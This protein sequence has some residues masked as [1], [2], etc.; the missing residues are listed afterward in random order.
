VPKDLDAQ[1]FDKFIAAGFFKGLSAESKAKWRKMAAE[2]EGQVTGIQMSLGAVTGGEGQIGLVYVI[3]CK[4]ADKLMG[5][6]PDYVGVMSEIYKA[7]EGEIVSKLELKYHKGLEGV[8]DTKL[9]AISI[10]HPVLTALPEGDR[11]KLKAVLGDDKIRFLVGK[12]D[13]KTVVM[14]LGGGKKF[15]ATAMATAKARSGKIPADPGAAKALAM[16]PKK[17]VGVGLLNLGNI[18]PVVKKVAAALGETPP[19]INLIAPTPLAGSIS[20]EKS[21]VLVVGYIPTDAIQGIVGAVMGAIMGGMM[22]GGGGPGAG[23]P[24]GF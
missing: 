19:P 18:M 3:E 20:I 13:A 17:R 16:L 10:E 5:M 23:G 8:G 11:A 15:V 14:T 7:T 22:G 24:G 6:L 12:A 21:D 1:M 2:F 4:S 9:D